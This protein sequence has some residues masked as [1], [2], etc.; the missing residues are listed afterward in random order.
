MA[1][2]RMV[3]VATW[4]LAG[5]SGHAGQLFNYDAKQPFDT[6]CESLD[7]RTD[8][9]IKGCGFTG[10]RGGKLNFILV[11]PKNVNPPFGGVL[12]QHGGGQSMSNYLSEALILSRAV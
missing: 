6:A 10:P 2:L 3:A 5:S 12:F 11:T 9:D 4:V 7:S 1:M 8:A